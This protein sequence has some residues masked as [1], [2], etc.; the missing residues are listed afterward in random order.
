M[1][2][3]KWL[4]VLLTFCMLFG[5]MSVTAYAEGIADDDLIVIVE[6]EPAAEGPIS[7]A[8]APVAEPAAER[9]GDPEL[10][11]CGTQVTEAN[12]ADVL[13]DGKVKFDFATSTLTFT[14]KP[15]ASLSGKTLINA[16]NID[17]TVELPEGGLTA[18]CGE[19]T[20]GI[21]V[22]GGTLTINGDLEISVE[23]DEV[24]AIH[25][26]NELTFNGNLSGSAS[27]YMMSGG[28]NY[29]VKS[30][31]GSV[32]ITGNYYM[33]A[34]YMS[35]FCAN[36]NVTVG[37][38]AELYCNSSNTNAGG[39]R[40]ENGSV[41]IAGNYG[42]YQ[43]GI[44]V[45]ADGDITIGG[46]VKLGDSYVD[47]GVTKYIR[48]SR[49]LISE[50][51][52]IVCEKDVTMY[53]NNNL[54]VSNNGEE[55][56][57]IKGETY[58]NSPSSSSAT[59]VAVKAGAG[60]ISFNGNLTMSCGGD[61]ALYAKK[62]ITVDG[63]AYV[64]SQTSN[65]RTYRNRAVVSEDGSITVTG[66]LETYSTNSGV[67]A[68]ND[69]TVGGDALISFARADDSKT[70][71]YG[72][73]AETGRISVA[74]TFEALGKAHVSAFA[75]TDFTVNGNVNI[76]NVET[77]AVGIESEGT[78]SFVSG[79][80]DV[81]AGAVA[82]R[83]AEGIV[84]PVGFGVTLPE[85]GAVAELEDGFTVTEA[86]KTTVAAHAIISGEVV[87]FYLIRPDWNIASINA[88]ELFTPN[89]DN[90]AEYQLS[91]K[92]AVGD[93]IKVVRVENGAITG[94]W[95]DGEHTQY[96]V[97]E[98]HAGD[99]T[100]YFKTEYD[101][102]WAEFGG[103][104]YIAAAPAPTGS[105]II[106]D[107]YTNGLAATSIDAEALYTGEVTFT[108][109]SD[110]ND[111]AVAVGLVN[112]DGTLTRLACTTAD[113]VHS[114]TVTVADADVTIALV[115][116]GD[117]DLNGKVQTRDGTFVKQVLVELRQLDAEKGA[118][119]IFAVDQNN[120]GA[121]QN[122][123]ATMISQVIVGTRSYAW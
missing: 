121:M 85:N 56:I 34:D 48:V 101:S 104:F 17:L 117:A 40:A 115:L 23:G 76:Q 87:Q 109:S 42:F 119:Q 20:E 2:L 33:Y 113:G 29:G 112:A 72:I 3:R 122:R 6:D 5:L 59:T 10:W 52:K 95:P 106:V 13:G 51:G 28:K 37:G 47:N 60:P 38:N 74:G 110:E 88:A 61:P 120:D 73:K 26:D 102:A 71:D 62:D 45:Y 63:N 9:A 69:I 57:L 93:E 68:K 99:V 67:Y 39:I 107:D 103:Y 22:T 58:L 81:D 19:V 100:I 36:G 111:T 11:V 114:F 44:A 53:V 54:L 97:D 7:V 30:E 21:Y 66:K 55:G 77:T 83:A 108:V 78:V 46:S 79:K 24:A 15:T 14:G 35:L 43:K 94:W 64:S 82:I 89:P 32:T 90:A 8:E 31:G 84:I 91:T 27:N 92:L 50:N 105:H 70:V 4:S 118:L 41:T 123:E 96:H 16:A 86:D 18:N 80:W 1:K 25:V 49:G 116:K 65:S 12:A 75:G 98:A